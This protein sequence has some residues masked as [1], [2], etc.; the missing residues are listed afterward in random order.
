VAAASRSGA[1]YDAGHGAASRKGRCWVA[2]EGCVSERTIRL[3]F[4]GGVARITL[5]R[6]PLNILTLSAIEALG[7]TLED[8]ARRPD[9]KAVVLAAE[10]RAF[11]AGVAV[12]DHLGERVKPMLVAF[13]RV[14]RTLHG[15]DCA[16]VAAVQGPALGGGAE[17]AAFC[18][19]VIAS[20]DATFGQPEIK[21]GVFPP[22]AALHYPVRIGVARTIQLLLSGD[23]LPA[24]EAERIGL[25]DRVVPRDGLADAVAAALARLTDKSA[26]ALRLTKRAVRLGTAGDF[27]AA[28]ATL[29]ALYLDELM[30]TEDAEEGLRAF[31][32]KRAPVWK[33]R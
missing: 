2:E 19:L 14:F 7:S 8:V 13:H 17:L 33:N 24:R 23:A 5:A 10:G 26:A 18:D 11:C 16:T 27:E 25:I 1:E 31:M 28:L 32:A 9:V 30:R 12:E 29:E 15:L 6:P 3:D 20:E 22:I 21:L 4:E